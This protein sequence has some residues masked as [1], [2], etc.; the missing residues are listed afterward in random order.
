MGLRGSRHRW[1]PPREAPD[2]S[3]V[4][5]G[6]HR[7]LRNISTVGGPRA[8]PHKEAHRDPFAEKHLVV[9]AL[10]RI[11]A[12]N[13]HTPAEARSGGV[14]KDARCRLDTGTPD[15]RLGAFAAWV[16]WKTR[17]STERAR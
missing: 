5:G 1:S 7:T 11:N 9:P 16:W 3:K 10:R 17:A 15:K 8:A 4:I 6:M 2:F 12:T 14:V 13:S